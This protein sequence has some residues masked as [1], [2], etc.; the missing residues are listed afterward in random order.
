[1]TMINSSSD[2]PSSESMSVDIENA[3]MDQTE[4]NAIADPDKIISPIEIHDSRSRISPAEVN[5]SSKKMIGSSS[6][7]DFEIRDSRFQISN[8]KFSPAEKYPTDSVNADAMDFSDEELDVEI[9]KE[10]G[11]S[12]CSSDSD[13][14]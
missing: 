11:L 6:N 9:K 5:S 2:E 12:E 14:N 1:M 7:Q 4:A 3:F 13:G 10:P 8:Q